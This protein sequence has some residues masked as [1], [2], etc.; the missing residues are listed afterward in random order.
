MLCGLP[1]RKL[2]NS[3]TRTAHDTTTMHLTT[4]RE[5]GL[6]TSSATRRCGLHMVLPPCWYGGRVPDSAAGWRM[7]AYLLLALR[8]ARQ[9]FPSAPH[10]LTCLNVADSCLRPGVTVACPFCRV[11][12]GIGPEPCPNFRGCS[13]RGGNRRAL[14]LRR[15]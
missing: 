6:S 7:L 1:R 8:N 13:G 11:V 12:A 2:S 4:S 9:H 10:P 3:R 5:G 15:G 14:F